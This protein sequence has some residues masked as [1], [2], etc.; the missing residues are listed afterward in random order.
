[1]TK[2]IFEDHSHHSRHRKLRELVCSVVV[3][4][5]EVVA[6]HLSQVNAIALAKLADEN[7]GPVKVINAKGEMVFHTRRDKVC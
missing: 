2:I 6:T 7:H 4:S 5:G 3:A 1:M